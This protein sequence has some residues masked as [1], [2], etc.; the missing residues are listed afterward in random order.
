MY[1]SLHCSRQSERTGSAETG[2]YGDD[3]L[4]AISSYHIPCAADATAYRV[5]DRSQQLTSFRLS[6]RY[7]KRLV[8]MLRPRHT[9]AHARL[10]V[11]AFIAMHGDRHETQLTDVQTSGPGTKHKMSGE[12]PVSG[13]PKL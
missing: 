13:G 3:F 8:A 1:R 5:R 9:V 12:N 10:A 7:G 2:E 6:E 11:A 4:T